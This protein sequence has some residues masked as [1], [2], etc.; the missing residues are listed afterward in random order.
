M[1]VGAERD[2]LDETGV[3]DE[4]VADRVAFVVPD[5]EL[6]SAR[7]D[8]LPVRAIRHAEVQE[9]GVEQRLTLAG[10]G[11]PEPD[12][13]SRGGDLASVGVEGDAEDG[14]DL[15]HVDG[16]GHDVESGVHGLPGSDD[17][18][19]VR[20]VPQCAQHDARVGLWREAL[21]RKGFLDGADDLGR[22][23]DG[24]LRAG[25]LGQPGRRGRSELDIGAVL[26]EESQSDNRQH[27]HD[28]RGDRLQ[29]APFGPRDALRQVVGR[30]ID[31]AGN[32]LHPR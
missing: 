20:G 29:P 4:R 2:G 3:A 6:G 23:F 28:D 1:A 32:Q 31:D 13:G 30:R 16:G 27:D 17:L 7:D 10:L 15:L 21:R 5:L 8:A 22:A 25:M 24:Q 18:P 9:P 14:V 19:D 26:L 11:I 12:L